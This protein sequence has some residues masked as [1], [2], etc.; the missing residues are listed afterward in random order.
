MD[1][2]N[3]TSPL[4]SR[5]ASEAMRFNWSDTKK[6]TTWRRLWIA[7]AEAEQSL[8]LPITD[9]QLAELREHAT[10]VDYDLAAEYEGKLRHDVMAHVHA[11]G[12]VAPD[13]RAIVHL[14]ATSCFVGDNTD[15]LVL[16]DSLDV[17]LPK[18]AAVADQLATFA[19]TFALSPAS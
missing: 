19:R 13:A 7:L 8:G 1:R 2:E 15:L 10:D 5:Y 17:L 16:R 4:S 12:D 18:L 3:Y 9:E 14:G 6:F 11:L